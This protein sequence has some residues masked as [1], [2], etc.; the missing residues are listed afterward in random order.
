MQITQELLARNKRVSLGHASEHRLALDFSRNQPVS[1]TRGSAATA[2]CAGVFYSV[3][4]A[5]SVYVHASTDF[6]ELVM[7]S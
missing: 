5:A 4:V 3:M 2:A 6:D 7:N 1:T